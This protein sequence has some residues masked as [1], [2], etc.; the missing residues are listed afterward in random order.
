MSGNRYVVTVQVVRGYHGH[1]MPMD[2]GWIGSGSGV[3]R[4][5]IGSGS[6]VDREWIGSGSFLLVDWGVSRASYGPYF[7]V[8]WTV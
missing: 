8:F 2:Q 7:L 6:G 3:A 1:Y 4:E 5:W